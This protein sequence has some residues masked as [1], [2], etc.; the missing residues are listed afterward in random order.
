MGDSPFI[1]DSHPSLECVRY[2]CGQGKGHQI[3]AT[4]LTPDP[5]SLLAKTCSHLVKS[6]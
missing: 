4:W 5:S 3:A 2:T 6:T 1:P